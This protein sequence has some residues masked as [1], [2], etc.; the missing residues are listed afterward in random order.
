MIRF[1]TFLGMGN[2][3]GGVVC[4]NPCENVCAFSFTRRKKY[5]LLELGVW[6][7]TN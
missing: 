4:V 2:T 5:P 6:V 7:S 3:R 1:A